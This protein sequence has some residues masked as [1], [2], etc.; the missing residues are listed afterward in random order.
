MSLK[1][2]DIR[3]REIKQQQVKRSD[4]NLAIVD[5][6][7][8]VSNEKFLQFVTKSNQIA[9]FL[10]LSLPTKKNFL[11]DLENAAIIRE[12]HVYGAALALGT[13][14]TGKAQ[15]LGLG[16]E[17][18]NAAKQ[19][20]VQNGYQNLAVISAVGTREY[21]RHRGFVDNGLYQSMPL[22]LQ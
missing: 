18:I 13:K 8:T 12:I 11:T 22:G 2:A 1:G 6:A 14:E 15:H 16:S 19:I 17:L 9:S 20:A 5:Y 7:A 21:Y 3:S 10:R 4:L